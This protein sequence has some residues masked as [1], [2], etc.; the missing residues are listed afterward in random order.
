VSEAELREGLR[1]A[2]GDEPPLRFDPD[3]L[4][5][6]GRHERRRRRALVAVMAA[7]LAITGTVLSL[8]GLLVPR[9][10]TGPPG[11]DVAAPPVLTTTAAPS[12]VASTSLPVVSPVDT[13]FLSEYASQRL[14]R[15]VPAV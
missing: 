8:P 6:R 13:K 4:I 11:I 12:P 15:V 9:P 1:A 2:V 3:E 10:G 7:T 14:V 5:R